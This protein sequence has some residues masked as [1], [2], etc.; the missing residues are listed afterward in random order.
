MTEQLGASFRDPSGF[1]FEY[2]GQVYRQVNQAYALAYDHL[3]ASGL[4]KTLIDKGLLIEHEEVERPLAPLPGIAYK[5][6]HPRQLA[7]VSYPYE[8]SFSQLKH[9]ALVTLRI[10]KLA[11][12][13]GMSLKDASA[14]N[15][16]FQGGRPV[17]IDTLSFEQYTEGT[18]WVAYRQF[19]QHFLAPLVLM[20]H[21]DVRLSQLLRIYIDGIP[22]DLASKLLPARSKLNPFLSLHIHAHAS[23]QRRYADQ[24]EHAAAVAA[25]TGRKM[26]QTQML[27]LLESLESGV[28]KL[29]WKPTGTEWA[30]YYETADH[31]SGAA[32]AE[33]EKIVAGFLDHIQPENVWDLGANR[34]VFSRI[35]SQRGIPTLAFDIDPGA[36]ERNYLTCVAHK[37]T[38]LLPLLMDLTNP[39]PALG[40]HN[41]ERAALIERAPAH[42]AF[43]LAL[44]HHLT[45]SNNVPL[46]QLADFFAALCRH[47]IIEFVP[48]TDPQVKRLLAS[49]ADIFPDYTQ[50][51]FEKIFSGRFSVR[52]SQ[53]VQGSER[54]LYWMEKRAG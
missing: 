48:K 16:Q 20:A 8:W 18:P 28:R 3:L 17:F 15:I 45:I 51:T 40:W 21:V 49:R 4:Y 27:G 53:P 12:Q 22:L 37:E 42:T 54:R 6:L 29:E 31:Y 34:G 24:P 23:A 2:E 25:E 19:C 5:V 14:Y 9:A 52:A 50:E 35:A 36:V 11:L 33:K 7:F 30:D 32:M 1:L 47:L 13:S 44:I 43:A 46:P 41:R 38:N 39:S 10:Q 26:T